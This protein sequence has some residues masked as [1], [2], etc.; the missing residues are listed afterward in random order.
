[1]RVHGGRR[2][3]QCACTT[4]AAAVRK[5]YAAA[6]RVLSPALKNVADTVD[7]AVEDGAREAADARVAAGDSRR[8]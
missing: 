4:A 3:Q 7:E 6:V 8:L 1:M 2:Q 5:H